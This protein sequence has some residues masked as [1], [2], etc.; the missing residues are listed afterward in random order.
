MNENTQPSAGNGSALTDTIVTE[1]TPKIGSKANLL[2]IDADGKPVT[3]I[4]HLREETDRTH[5]RTKIPERKKP[6]NVGFHGTTPKRKR[7]AKSYK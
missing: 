3:D 6:K 2:L 5:D 1:V 4:D 7:N